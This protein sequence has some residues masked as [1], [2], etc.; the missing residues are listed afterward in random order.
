MSG[1]DV[2]LMKTWLGESSR[3]DDFVGYWAEHAWAADID[4][5]AV[6]GLA[7]DAGPIVGREAMCAYV[8]EWF[9][10]FDDLQLVAEEITDKG[11]GKLIVRLRMAGTAKGSGVPAEVRFF[12]AYWIRDGRIVRGREYTTR[13]E[14][15]AAVR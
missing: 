7:D 9:E 13:D 2:E 6:E 14:A 4:H 1:T 11:H 10:L 3:A 15:E 8:G 5:R 12:V